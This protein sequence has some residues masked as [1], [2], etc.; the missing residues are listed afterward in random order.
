MV[1]ARQA[2]S[3][4]EKAAQMR[5]EAARKETRA[6]NT[7]IV[8]V[9]VTVLA[10][11]IGAGVLVQTLRHDR[12][13]KAAAAAAPP[14]NTTNGG[15]LVGNT[16]AKVTIEVYEDFICPACKMFEELHGAEMAA[17]VKAGTANV[18][19]RPVAILDEQSSTQYSTRALNAVGAVIAANPQAF[20]KYHDLLFANQPPEQ[21]AGLPDS[22]LIELAVQAG[23]ERSAVEPAITSLKYLGWTQTQTDQFSRKHS[24]N[25][26]SSTPTVVVNGKRLANPMSPD[27]LKSVVEAGAKG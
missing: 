23:V 14:A 17:W 16:T 24:V 25:G 15:M 21:S 1:N 20:L 8:A 26:R 10:L 12:D 7:A 11:A 2:K 22:Q 27:E 5:A 6:R 3:A 13:A 4:R 18:M 19:Y 9:V